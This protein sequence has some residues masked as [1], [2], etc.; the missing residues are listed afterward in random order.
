MRTFP[1]KTATGPGAIHPRALDHLSDP[2]LQA[3]ASVFM[4]C[5]RLRSWPLERLESLMARLPK[6][7]G[8]SRL[9]ALLNTMVRVWGRVRRPLSACWEIDHRCELIYGTGPGKSA[10]DSAFSHNLD[11]EMAHVLGEHS[12]TMLI[13]LWKC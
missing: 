7:E 3:M 8:W 5:E 10:S 6:P 2:C 9:I 12:V 1:M 11:A 13:D 4:Q